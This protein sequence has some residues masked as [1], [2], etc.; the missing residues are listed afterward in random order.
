MDTTVVAIKKSKMIDP[1]QI[2]QFVNEVVLLS[3]I[4]HPNIVKLVGCC[5]E[6][7]VPLLAYEYIV[8]ETLHHHLH[9]QGR[10]S[11]LTWRMRLK[12]AVETSQALAYMHSSTKIIHRDI[13]LSN[14]LLTDDFTVKVS[15]FGISR[16]VP[17]DQM[18][19]STAVQGT[20]GYIDPEYFSSGILTEK[21]DVY[22]F[23]VV[24]VELLTGEKV[25]S[26]MVT[27]RNRSLADH[28]VL[29]L[30]EGQLIE[31]LDDQ[32]KLDG[33]VEQ[34]NRVAQLVKSCL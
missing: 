34:L 29:S 13:K 11:S 23:G 16:L 9:G 1:N 17:K 5:L 30:N 15:D 28:F 25:N 6:T 27:R 3:Q 24:L 32:I 19:V 31:I 33:T 14:I 2:V 26:N 22:S 18:Q 4:N 7:H 8:N 10:G 12:F 21:S 20:L